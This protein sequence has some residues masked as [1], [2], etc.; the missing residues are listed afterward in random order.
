MHVG[1]A[2]MEAYVH[3][4]GAHALRRMLVNGGHSGA[5]RMSLNLLG[6]S[7]QRAPTMAQ[8]LVSCQSKA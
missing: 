2:K 5:L 1:M 6:A 8:V 7:I 4:M 3:N